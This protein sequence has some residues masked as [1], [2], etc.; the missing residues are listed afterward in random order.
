MLWLRYGRWG[1]THEH[2]LV[3]VAI[4]GLFCLLKE[5]VYDYVFESAE[6]RGSSLKDFAFYFLGMLVGGF[7]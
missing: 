6:A 3:F 5:F 2:L 1:Y 7:A 4:F